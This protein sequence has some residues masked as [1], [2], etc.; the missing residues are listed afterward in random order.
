MRDPIPSDNLLKDIPDFKGFPKEAGRF[1]AGLALHNE[2]PWF[3]A[4]RA[5]Y[6]AHVL[7]PMRA[8][9]VAVG[10]R[11]RKKIPKLV[12]DPR[13]GGSVMRIAR[14]TRFSGDKSPYKTWIAAH[15]RDGSAPSKDLSAGFYIHVDAGEV[16][17]GGGIYMFED[18]QLVRFR[19]ALDDPKMLKGLR[20]ILGKLDDFAISG[21]T[22]KRTPRGFAADHPAGELLLHKGLYAGTNLDLRRARTVAALD[23]ASKVYDQLVPLHR[24]LMQHVVLSPS[25]PRES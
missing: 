10:Q 25:A 23:D 19:R 8:F 2:R 18:D 15:L 14:D 7:G 5:E 24:W 1:F 21:E 16:Y 20:A 13:V 6:E 11:L 9:V 4:H 3:D 12:A 17:A 22:L